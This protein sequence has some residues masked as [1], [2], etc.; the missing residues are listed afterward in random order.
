[1]SELPLLQA[2]IACLV[3][4]VLVAGLLMAEYLWSLRDWTRSAWQR[5][6]TNLVLSLPHLL[7]THLLLLP[8]LIASALVAEEFDFGLVRWVPLSPLP[9]GVLA[10]LG[11]DYA[12]YLWHRATHR[13]AWL[14]RFHRVHHTDR[15][16]SLVTVLRFHFGET[17]C[18]APFRAAAVALVGADV[19][20]VLV[21][22]LVFQAGVAFHHSNWDISRGLDRFLQRLVVTPRLHGIHHSNRELE[23]DSNFSSLLTLWDR[24]HRTFLTGVRQRSITIGAPGDCVSERSVSELFAAPFEP[25]QFTTNHQELFDSQRGAS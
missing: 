20:I 17:A 21:Y 9:A 22:E 2:A 24:I 5:T 13:V 1:M 4:F 7:V 15:D 11:L 23:T 14:W 10:F 12:L 18:S 6:W 8:L 25:N 16:L 19:T 3:L